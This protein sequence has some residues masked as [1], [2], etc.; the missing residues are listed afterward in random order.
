MGS[1]MPEWAKNAILTTH[2]TAAPQWIPCTMCHGSCGSYQHVRWSVER[3]WILC[4]LCMGGGGR[5]QL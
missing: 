4:P 1:D 3:V 5:F 2:S